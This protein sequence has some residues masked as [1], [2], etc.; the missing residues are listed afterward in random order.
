[1]HI[2]WITHVDI[3]AALVIVAMSSL[4]YGKLVVADHRVEDLE[5]RT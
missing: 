3:S 5:W 2:S 1:M 4:G